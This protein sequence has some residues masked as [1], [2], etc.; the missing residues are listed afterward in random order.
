M[1]CNWNTMGFFGWSMMILFWVAVVALI[2][3]AI[4]SAGASRS[5]PK[6]DAIAILE[7]RFAAG[8]I[9]RDE[10]EDKKRTLEQS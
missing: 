1:W 10:F 5:M 3:W 8:E 9:D 2:I 7:R 6:S 4:R